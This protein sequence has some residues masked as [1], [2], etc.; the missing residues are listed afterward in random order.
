MT[1]PQPESP[2]WWKEAVFYQVYPR[3]FAD[4]NGDGI[5]DLPGITGKLDYLKRLGVDGLWLSPIYA[6]PNDD[7]GYDISDYLAIG[8][9]Y[10]TLKDFQ[11]L[12]LGLK[13]RGLRLILDQV[14]NHT[15]DEH[16]WFHQSRSSR[17]NPRRDWYHWLDA[18]T[19]G[20]G[21]RPVPPNNW[22]SVFGGSAWEWE[23]STQQYY[24]HC[25]SRK[26]PDLNW[27]NP[28]VR[29]ALYEVLTTWATRGADGFR[30][31]VINMI[32]KA[33]GYPDVPRPAGNTEPFLNLDEYGVN[34]PPIH[35]YLREMH[36]AVFAG[37]DLYSVGET[38]WVGAHNTIDFTGYHRRELN[39]AFY[40]YFHECASGQAHFE[41]FSNLYE[42][43]RGKSW[44]TVTLGNHDSRRSLSR[45]GDPVNY[46]HASA[47]LLATWLL[48]LPAT[49]FL[50]QGEEL[51]LTDHAYSTIT[52][53]RDIQTVN[54]YQELVASGVSPEKALAEVRVTSRDNGR[55]P[56]PWDATP[57][58]GFSRGVPWLPIAGDHRPF[59]AAGQ[60]DDPGSIFHAYARLLAL[61]KQVKSL[62]Y[63]DFTPIKESGQVLAYRRGEWGSH[64]AVCVILNW[65]SSAQPWPCPIPS[66]DGIL[67]ANHGGIAYSHLRPW[68]AV[69]FTAARL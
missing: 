56:I 3:S 23:A 54:R 13:E 41:N 28:D 57:G 24:L 9:E 65:G 1:V 55:S 34:Q 37:R 18:R 48:T 17:A 46:R 26:Q 29:R 44:L 63:G 10:G 42:A 59:H 30:L 64:P 39:A 45:F 69:I 36:D 38:W 60:V 2:A 19:D 35:E 6:S 43:T 62:V 21:D 7:N 15:S 58:A 61:R 16:E 12:S 20:E 50:F 22:R 8:P 14:L 33:E 5:G 27:R 68:E 53:Y 49:P 40:F 4:S 51:G 66:A 32:A 25:F 47:S 11:E 52:D 67:Y 31:D